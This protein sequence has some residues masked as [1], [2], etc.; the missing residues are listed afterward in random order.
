MNDSRGVCL[1]TTCH[2]PLARFVPGIENAG[3]IV[4]DVFGALAVNV[5]SETHPATVEALRAL[6]LPMVSSHHGAGTV[7]IGT[8]RKDALALGLQTGSDRLF[9]SDL[10]HILRWLSTSRDKVEACLT[11]HD[12]DLIVVGRSLAAM[13]EA[14]QRLRLTEELVNH[15]YGLA[16]GLDER[17]DLMIAMRLMT[18]GAARTIVAHSRE[19]S[20]ANDVTW[21]MLAAARG[22]AVG[23]FEGDGIRFLARDDFG[24]DGDHRD[25]DPHEWHRRM[26][27]ATAH[28]AAIV[29][30]DPT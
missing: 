30:F 14:P 17:W 22:G 1:A 19:T 12:D 2:D 28:V 29:E 11:E 27:T 16:N 5:T 10:D 25:L 3:D 18:R 26:I 13:A 4:A 6:D 24:Q 21:P 9:Y 23:Y 15:V 7:G 8:A 20:I